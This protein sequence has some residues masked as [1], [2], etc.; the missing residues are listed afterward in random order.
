LEPLEDRLSPATAIWTGASPFDSD[1]TTPENWQ[2]NLAPSPGDDLSFPAGTAQQSNID[3]FAAGTTFRS[4]TISA[5]T[6]DSYFLDG[7]NNLILTAGIVDNGTNTSSNVINIAQLTLGADQQFAFQNSGSDLKINSPVNL[8]SFTLTLNSTISFNTFGTAGGLRGLISGSGGITKTGIGGWELATDNSYTGP[9]TINQGTLAITSSNGLGAL[10]STTLVNPGAG[11]MLSPNST[12]ISVPNPITINGTGAGDP[13]PG[14]IV[15]FHAFAVPTLTGTI[16]LGSASEIF[17]ANDPVFTGQTFA[18]GG[19]VHTNGFDL[20]LAGNLTTI[21]TN[22]GTVSG[23][24]RVIQDAQLLS[25]T[26]TISNPISVNNGALSPGN[27]GPGVLATA[28]VT[29]QSG[30]SYQ[31]TLSG[32]TAGTGYSQLNVTGAVSL[33]N[34]TLNAALNFSPAPS[35]RFVI[36]QSTGTIS[37]NFNGLPD[38]STVTFGSQTFI[39]RYQNGVAG[40]DG[41]GPN[42]FTGRVVLFST[43]VNTLTTVTPSA[44]P[45]TTNQLVTF[46]ATVTAASGGAAAVV[47]QNSVSPNV[48]GTVTYHDGANLLGTATLANGIATLTIGLMAGAHDISAVYNGNTNFSPSP[49]S[50]NVS[51]IVYSAGAGWH[52]VLTGD[53]LGTG[54]QDIAGM[55]ASGQWWVALSTGTSF[56]NHFWGGWDPTAGWQDVMTGDFLGNGKPDI[57][58]RAANG[59]WWLAV[60]NGSSFTNQLWGG[61]NPNV[62]WVDV[63]VG[64]FNGDGK[65][66]IVGRYS[67]TGQWWVAQSTGSSFTN[68]LWASWNPNVTWVDVNVGNFAGNKTSDLTGRWLQGGSWWTAV[69]T[70]SSFNTSLWATWN[71]NVTWVDIK[72]GDFN[73]DGMTDL[74]G[75]WL[76]GGSWWAAIS[77]GSSF[78][79][80]LWASWNPNATWVDVQVGDFN[81]DGQADIA[82]RYFQ[83]GGWYV[84]ISTGSSFATALWGGWNT[85]AIWVDVRTA[86]VNGDGLPDLVG[87][88]SAAGQW[89]AAI[90]NGSN[91]YNNQLWTTW[92]N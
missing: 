11:L 89:W 4:I 77:S 25:G 57:A 58:G 36:M 31:E 7:N 37:G 48:P 17:T 66:D 59:Q 28:D 50:A 42:D 88:W 47:G 71:P 30:T 74:T 15:V 67:Q 14:A 86:D 87:R 85:A 54:K 76:Q 75:R 45:A 82:A 22:S 3:D 70:G 2:G 8:Q 60:P 44:N 69:S 10:T 81:K 32:T 39:I 65:A 18:I 62:S 79:T 9:T 52:D 40:S 41:I 19:P 27:G 51:E 53:F 24:G 72:V 90:S 78:T 20:T 23:G 33:G 56:T 73:N 5:G 43:P 38:N 46:T 80:S 13:E 92:V 83:G 26:G 64:D 29:F 21:L 61:W 16:T 55:T 84:G 35:S 68:S 12:D 1:W 34:S 6:S 91:G 63:K 49:P